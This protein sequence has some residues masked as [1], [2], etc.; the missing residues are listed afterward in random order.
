GNQHNFIHLGL[1]IESVQRRGNIGTTSIYEALRIDIEDLALIE[2]SR[3]IF[4]LFWWQQAVVFMC[5]RMLGV[6][7]V[8]LV[9]ETEFGRHAHTLGHRRN[10]PAM[11]NNPLIVALTRPSDESPALVILRYRKTSHRVTKKRP[12]RGMM[13]RGRGP[14][15]RATATFTSLSS[16]CTPLIRSS[17]LSNF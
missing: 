16:V 6:V 4:N 1:L 7:G 3:V 2:C 12:Q 11:Q 14:S 8:R 10:C 13:S 5:A 17:I 9:A 15:R